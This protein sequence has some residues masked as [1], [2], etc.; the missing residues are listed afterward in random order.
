MQG[1]R[2]KFKPN[3]KA[4][5][6]FEALRGDESTADLDQICGVHPTRCAFR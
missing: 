6:A 4:K 1:K 5:V 2:N 3:F